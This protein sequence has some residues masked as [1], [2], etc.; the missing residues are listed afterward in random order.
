ML[1]INDCSNLLMMCPEWSLD[2]EFCTIPPN[3]TLVFEVELIGVEWPVWEN[4]PDVGETRRMSSVTDEWD[5]SIGICSCNRSVVIIP[6]PV[7]KQF[8]HL[9]QQHH[10]LV[11]TIGRTRGFLLE[12]YPTEEIRVLIVSLLPIKFPKMGD[13][14]HW[15]L[16]CW[17]WFFGH[18]TIWDW[19]GGG[20]V[21]SYEAAV[22]SAV[23]CLPPCLCLC[24]C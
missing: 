2:R 16:H 18:A 1:L 4:P 12:N 19:A 24:L 7:P 14:Q 15:I 9:L 6:T 13:L 21:V 5:A 10:W 11:Q 23:F 22:P 17:P 8:L 3:A 20:S